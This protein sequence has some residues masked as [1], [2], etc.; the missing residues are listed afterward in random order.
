MA[1]LRSNADLLIMTLALGAASLAYASGSF[2]LALVLH[3]VGQ[4][5]WKAAEI[6]SVGAYPL[7][8]VLTAWGVAALRDRWRRRHR[9]A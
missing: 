5:E 8:W 1:R 7:A 3:P 4:Q 9:R 2:V 6:V